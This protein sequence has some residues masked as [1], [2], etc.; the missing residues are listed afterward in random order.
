[1]TVQLQTT[2]QVWNG[3]SSDDKPT[4]GVREGSTFHCVDT[5]EEFIFH[6]DMWIQDLRKINA[7]KEAAM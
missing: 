4:S 3:H 6:N 7:I 5:G 1:M 2:I